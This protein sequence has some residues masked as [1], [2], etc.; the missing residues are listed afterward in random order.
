MGRSPFLDHVIA[1]SPSP[2]QFADSLAVCMEPPF[3]NLYEALVAQLAV[4]PDIF[5]IHGDETG[6]V[7]F[8][9]KWMRAMA[10]LR[11]G[12]Q[13]VGG[14]ADGGPGGRSV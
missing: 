11:S 4:D 2:G 13:A 7:G 8:G 9:E 5:R 12:R 14:D 6:A 10:E 3:D 1:V